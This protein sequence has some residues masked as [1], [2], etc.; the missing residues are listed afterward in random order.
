MKWV[1]I[2]AF[3][4]ALY[5]GFKWWFDASEFAD[6]DTRNAQPSW[7]RTAGIAL[8]AACAVV[9]VRAAFSGPTDYSKQDCAPTGAPLEGPCP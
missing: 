5:V 7:K 6:A 4:A 9:A 8:L 2:A 1:E 3:V